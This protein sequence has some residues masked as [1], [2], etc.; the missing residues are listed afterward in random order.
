MT[1]HEVSKV[2]V[3]A[4][5]KV[6]TAL[7]AGLLEESY[8]VWLKHELQQRENYRLSPRLQC[9]SPVAAPLLIKTASSA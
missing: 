9:R 5:L 7:G 6:H 3:D 1:P 8:K 4:A 2:F